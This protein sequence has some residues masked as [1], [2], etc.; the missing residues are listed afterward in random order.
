MA[1]AGPGGAA[2]AAVRG[3]RARNALPGRGSGRNRRAPGRDGCC[4][5]MVRVRTRTPVFKAVAPKCGQG[6][7]A[8]RV[9]IVAWSLDMSKT[10]ETRMEHCSESGRWAN[11]NAWRKWNKAYVRS[12]TTTVL[13]S[14]AAVSRRYVSQTRSHLF[15]LLSYGLGKSLHIIACI[16]NEM[17]PCYIEK[18]NSV[19]T[20]SATFRDR[21]SDLS[22]EYHTIELGNVQSG[23]WFGM[24]T[25]RCFAWIVYSSALCI[26]TDEH[27]DLSF[28]RAQRSRSHDNVEIH[29]YTHTKAL[30]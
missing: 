25:T 13:A 8:P 3:R 22:Q 27:P 21:I 4:Q 9:D 23:T 20:S 30:D 28:E 7:R 10:K 29:G 24:I 19:I 12:G 16:L 17:L 14:M 18:N 11:G 1:C 5:N 26:T 2:V 6:A 15:V